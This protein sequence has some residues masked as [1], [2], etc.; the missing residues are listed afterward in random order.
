MNNITSALLF[1]NLIGCLVFA[2]V[3]GWLIFSRFHQIEK[4][5]IEKYDFD[6]VL[7][8]FA[9]QPQ[10]KFKNSKKIFQRFMTGV[11]TNS[12]SILYIK[13]ETFRTPSLEVLVIV[14]NLRSF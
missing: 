8:T 5:E 14:G 1:C 3:I 2:Y 13:F 12:V 4:N 7:E 9:C 10:K 11:L 6:Y